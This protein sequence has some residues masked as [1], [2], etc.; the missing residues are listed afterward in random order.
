MK[1]IESLSL[2]LSFF[3]NF[4]LASNRFFFF[5]EIDLHTGT[6]L[7]LEPWRIFGNEFREGEKLMVCGEFDIQY[8]FA[9]RFFFLFSLFHVRRTRLKI[10]RA[11]KVAIKSEG[12]KFRLYWESLVN[13]EPS[14]GVFVPSKRKILFRGIRIRLETILSC[15]FDRCSTSIKILK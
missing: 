3:L 10:N 5:V 6:S 2:S 13:E 4:L 7:L 11:K 8:R 12:E 14:I 15:I 9:L 1:K